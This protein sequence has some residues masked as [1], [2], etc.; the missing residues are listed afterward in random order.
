MLPYNVPPLQ[1]KEDV[2][3]S[4][5]V[6]EYIKG[7][8][9]SVTVTR[10]GEYHVCSDTEEL[11][12]DHYLYLHTINQRIMEQA[13]N[14]LRFSLGKAKQVTLR[15]VLPDP[16]YEVDRVLLVSC[17]L[18]KRPVLLPRFREL[19]I[20][21]GNR[22]RHKPKGLYVPILAENTIP[23]SQQIDQWLNSKSNLNNKLDIEGVLLYGDEYRVIRKQPEVELQSR[24][25][26]RIGVVESPAG[27]RAKDSSPLGNTGSPVRGPKRLS[28]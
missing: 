17:E 5:T 4:V 21:V 2:S 10:G 14:M 6:L 22:L 19:M 7:T 16:M 3:G 23:T 1:F 26:D 9:F 13:D 20:Q 11:E 27:R 18:D 25:D 8:Y 12:K 28:D 15:C 24:S